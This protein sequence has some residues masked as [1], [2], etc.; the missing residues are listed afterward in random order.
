[1]LLVAQKALL[2]RQLHWLD[3]TT[4]NTLCSQRWRCLLLLHLLASPAAA[5]NA[6]TAVA[7]AGAAAASA[8][9]MDTVNRFKNKVSFWL[10]ARKGVELP[11]LVPAAAHLLFRFP[12][13]I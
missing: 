5:C 2:Q 9:I 4:S 12:P 7:A 8:A 10:Q 1:L 13:S 11:L 6:F 3:R